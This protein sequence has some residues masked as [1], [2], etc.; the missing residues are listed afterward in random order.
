METKKEMTKTQKVVFDHYKKLY[1]YSYPVK[2]AV[3]KT[4]DHLKN[5]SNNF[6]I[7]IGTTEARL[8]SRK[9]QKQGD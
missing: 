1:L 3:E 9:P 4:M 6:K 2:V 5:Y 8:E 7:F